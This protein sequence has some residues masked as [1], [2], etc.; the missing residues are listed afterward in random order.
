MWLVGMP[1][2]KNL[3]YFSIMENYQSNT[4]DLITTDETI[5]VSNTPFTIGV[6]AI[7]AFVLSLLVGNFIF[8]G[9]GLILFAGSFLL[10]IIGLVVSSKY[11]K[12]YPNIS[13]E[14]QKKLRV[15]KI[16]SLSTL[17]LTILAITA[18]I[19]LIVLIGAGGFGR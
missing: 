7:S 5:V 19:S 6:T 15:G 3:I 9:I 13:A 18:L 10:S 4:V 12:H 14:Q 11:K 17:I 1:F 2:H 16:L 8:P